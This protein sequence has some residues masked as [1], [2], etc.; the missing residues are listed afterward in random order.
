MREPTLPSPR[1]TAAETTGLRRG[2]RL[3]TIQKAAA[4]LGWSQPG[5]IIYGAPLGAAELNA[6]ANVAGTFTYSPA[7][8]TVLNAGAS[9]TLAATFTPA[10][11]ANYNGGTVNTTIDV[12]KATAT[13]TATGGTFTYDGQPHPATG[14]VTGVGE[15]ALGTPTF[16]Y[17]GGAAPPLTAGAYEVVA[18]YPGSANYEPASATTAIVIL[19]ATPILDWTLPQAIV[20]GTPLGAAQLNA[21]ANVAGTFTYSP[22]AGTVLN[23]GAAQV[24]TATFT[25][26][27]PNYSGA[28]S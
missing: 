16:T 20:Y 27:D 19:Q 14:V 26:A 2:P 1:S 23:A 18:T 10:D 5:A 22:A 4:V 15:A 6:T 25:P 3:V 12:S 13:V 21:T 17:N 11:A 9:Q 8:G 28:G 7:A 24:L